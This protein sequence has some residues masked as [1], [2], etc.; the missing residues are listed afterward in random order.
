MMFIGLLI[1]GGILYFIISSILVYRRRYEEDWEGGV[2]CT[3][4]INICL[5]LFWPFLAL[6][7]FILPF[8]GLYKIV[9]FV[10]DKIEEKSWKRN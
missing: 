4:F 3:T 9:A 2:N 6:A 5:F 1:L 7:I 10:G 8:Y